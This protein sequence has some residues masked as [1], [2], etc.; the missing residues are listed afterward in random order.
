M[1]DKRVAELEQLA[2]AEGFTLPMTAEQIIAIEDAGHTVDLLTGEVIANGADVG[3]WPVVAT[4][5]E[6]ER[7]AG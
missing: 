3:A 7:V 1:T 6:A 5:S 4:E 2:S